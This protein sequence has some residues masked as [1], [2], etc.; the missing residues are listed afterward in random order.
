VRQRQVSIRDPGLR[1]RRDRVGESLA[2]VIGR[3]V[4]RDDDLGGGSALAEIL[5]ACGEARRDAAS[6]VISREN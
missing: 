3:A 5:R 1:K 2:G 6:L 4:V